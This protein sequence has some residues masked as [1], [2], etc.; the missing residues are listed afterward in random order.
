[1]SILYI[2]TVAVLALLVWGTYTDRSRSACLR[3]RQY[4]VPWITVGFFIALSLI[5]TSPM[6]CE[7]A[8]ILHSTDVITF[9]ENGK[10]VV[11]QWGAFVGEL[12]EYSHMP[13]GRVFEI[14]EEA[15]QVNPHTKNPQ[16]R[17]IRYNLRAHIVDL[18]LFYTF[19]DERKKTRSPLLVT[20]SV[21]EAVEYWLYEF[22][23]LHHS[24]LAIF[25]NPRD[26]EQVQQLVL[27]IEEWVNPKLESQGIRIEVTGFSLPAIS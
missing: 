22:N 18:T 19:N 14:N 10:P 23:E 21:Q 11:H 1:M 6:Y 7:F 15:R 3:I 25:H 9:D 20:R 26:E 17:A 2:F 13:I 24:G 8:H 5:G 27:F 16:T 12:G 4:Y